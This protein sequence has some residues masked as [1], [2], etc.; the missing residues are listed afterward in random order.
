MNPPTPPTPPP[1]L[2]PATPTL[3]PPNPPAIPKSFILSNPEVHAGNHRAHSNLVTTAVAGPSRGGKVSKVPGKVCLRGGG[4]GVVP[5]DCGVPSA[6]P[7][8]VKARRAEA[9]LR[10]LGGLKEPSAVIPPPSALKR[11]RGG[12]RWGRKTLPADSDRRQHRLG[13]R[14]TKRHHSHLSLSLLSLSL[15]SPS[16]PLC[17]LSL[18]LS[19][20]SLTLFSISLAFCLSQS[21]L[22]LPLSHPLILS[23]PLN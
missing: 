13:L 1:P 8:R 7:R 21:S 23:L 5:G 22:S 14:E 4:V 16:L 19:F 15:S 20:F 18:T 3:P 10:P 9:P 11:E 17:L 2:H 6:A 12:R